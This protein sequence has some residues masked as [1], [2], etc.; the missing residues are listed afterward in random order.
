MTELIEY[1]KY[2]LQEPLIMAAEHFRL[3]YCYAEKKKEILYRNLKKVLNLSREMTID[4]DDKSILENSSRDLNDQKMSNFLHLISLTQN[5]IS[6]DDESE[7]FMQLQDNLNKKYGCSRENTMKD[8]D[9][10]YTF[11]KKE[12]NR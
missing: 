6:S 3:L 9:K 12:L 7:C 1:Y 8:V 10:L 5:Q 11:K 2:Y 4:K